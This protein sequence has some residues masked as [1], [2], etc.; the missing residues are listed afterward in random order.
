M[1][2]RIVETQVPDLSS[3]T[4]ALKEIMETEEGRNLAEELKVK[5]EA[6]TEQYK[7]M[8]PEQ[9]DRFEKEFS[10]KFKSS[11]DMLKKVVDEKI[12]SMETEEQLNSEESILQI[13][14]PVFGVI[15]LISVIG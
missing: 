14:L 7:E 1:D 3:T 12:A 6:L 11:M 4:E 8:T 13:A 10:T 2:P 9:R 5:M 15:L